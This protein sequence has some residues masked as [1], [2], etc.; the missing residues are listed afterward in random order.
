[1]WSGVHSLFLRR[2]IQA[3]GDCGL[4]LLLVFV[5]LHCW[6]IKVCFCNLKNRSSTIVLD[7]MPRYMTCWDGKS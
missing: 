6:I 3:I 1:M 5:A 4:L 7:V 2:G